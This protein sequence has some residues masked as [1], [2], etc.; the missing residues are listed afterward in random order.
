MLFAKE[1]SFPTRFS[2]VCPDSEQTLLAQAQAYVKGK[3]FLSQLSLLS[4]VDIPGV[5]V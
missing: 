3:G 1:K 5:C 2:K 4:D